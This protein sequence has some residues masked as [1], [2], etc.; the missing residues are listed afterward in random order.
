MR[1]GFTTL[2]ASDAYPRAI[3]LRQAVSLKSRVDLQSF[4]ELIRPK[5]LAL[6]GHLILI[7]H[8][9]SDIS[10]YGYVCLDPIKRRLSAIGCQCRQTKPLVPLPEKKSCV[11]GKVDQGLRPE[12][13]QDGNRET[14][15]YSGKKPRRNVQFA[16]RRQGI[17]FFAG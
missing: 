15:H 5:T 9:Y 7:G 17:Y 6:L 2:W 14:K 10:V 8:L 1:T 12:T 13:E 11:C 4:P 3:S 16:K